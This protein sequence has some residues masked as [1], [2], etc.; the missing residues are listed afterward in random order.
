LS[1]VVRRDASATSTSRAG[2]HRQ[3][4]ACYALVLAR[5]DLLPAA[6]RA[7]LAEA[8][9]WAL[10]NS[11]QLPAAAEAALLAVDL[12]EQ[13]DSTRLA[14]ALITLTRQLWLTERTSAAR[15][16]AERAVALTR[17][18]P[19]TPG[20]ALARLGLGG[21]LVLVDREEEGLAQLDQAIEIADRL[22][23][24]HIAALSHNYR[25]SALLQ[26]GDPAGEQVLLDS[27]E[28]ATGTGNHEY[29]MRGYY[30]LVEGLWRLGRYDEALAYLE[31]A[32]VYGRDRDFPA[33]S[34][35]FAARRCRWLAMTGRWDAA[36]VG[37]RRLLDGQDEPAMLGRETVPVLAR[38][39][40][41][42]GHPDAP[43][44]L[45]MATE[46]AERADV[47]EWLAPTGMAQ[48]ERAWL[49]GNPAAAGRYPDLLTARLSRPG[50]AVQRGE[51]LRYLQRLGQTVEPDS[52]VPERY[53]AGLRGDWRTAA[54]EWESFGDPYERALELADSG[55][56]EPTREALVVL[57]QL[58]AAPAAAMARRRLRGLGVTRLPRQPQPATRANPAG[59]TDREIEIL[60]LLGTGMS[61]AEIAAALVVSTRTVDHHVS[62]VLQK[63]GVRNRRE[64]AGRLGPLGLSG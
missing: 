23:A 7:A 35:M 45:A 9:A 46:H 62:A 52:Q 1:D 25:G 40:V 53:A 5:G 41:R 15:E 47:L 2:A 31:L 17:S 8:N 11:N 64:A 3:A 60:R 32:E 49:T 33:H 38:L 63:L 54:Q 27:I 42:Q 16:A 56:V 51:L 21:L 55:Q 28:L 61:N 29:V 12:F 34:Y 30:N 37:L 20:H 44:M 39:L 26:L 36:E 24:T 59:L 58:G 50:M 10:A 43:G 4:A 19:D 13:V 22:G 57:D 6:D 48:I 14:H 18:D